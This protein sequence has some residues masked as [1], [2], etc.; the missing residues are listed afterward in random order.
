MKAAERETWRYIPKI[1]SRVAV[2][3]TLDKCVQQLRKQLIKERIEKK[4]GQDTAK[5]SNRVPSFFTSPSLVNMSGLAITERHSIGEQMIDGSHEDQR[6]ERYVLEIPTEVPAGWKGMG[7]RGNFSS[8]S[9][10]RSGSGIFLDGDS[11]DE[12]STSGAY[13]VQKQLPGEIPTH[14]VTKEQS[15]TIHN[16]RYIK[17]SSM[18]DFYYHKKN[19]NS[20]SHNNIASAY[21]EGQ[22]QSI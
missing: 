3:M 20:K 13:N 6:D 21:D 16:K 15:D 1:K 19:Q 9:L 4:Q 2:E 18:A 12:L 10:N 17:T 7:L 5:F 14:C 8:G 22:N 11:E